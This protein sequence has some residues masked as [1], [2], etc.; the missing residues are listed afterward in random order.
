MCSSWE[1][2][3]GDEAPHASIEFYWRKAEACRCSVSADVCSTDDVIAFEGL[4][5]GMIFLGEVGR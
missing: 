2:A 1:D 4:D 5:P 3:D